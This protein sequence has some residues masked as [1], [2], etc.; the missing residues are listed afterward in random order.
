MKEF[1]HRFAY[2]LWHLEAGILLPRW[3]IPSR[4]RAKF[5]DLPVPKDELEQIGDDIWYSAE[6]IEPHTDS[7][8]TGK[9]TLG[10]VLQNDLG[11]FL[12]AEG[13][14]FPL[15]PGTVY[16]INGR[17]EHAALQGTEGHE[18]GRFVARIW[19][20]SRKNEPLPADFAREALVE[21]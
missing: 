3:E 7:T 4:L 20:V 21:N 10:I 5:V 18:N 17:R 12:H 16:R 9:I 2:D 1:C 13:R 19:D 11:L 8:D 15:P 14:D 6:A